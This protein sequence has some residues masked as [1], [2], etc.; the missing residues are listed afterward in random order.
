MTYQSAETL[1]QCEERLG[2][3]LKRYTTTL[4]ELKER[5]HFVEGENSIMTYGE[6][7]GRAS[8]TR[9]VCLSDMVD[10]RR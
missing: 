6:R 7:T 5:F 1:A 2:Q 4:E 10:P 8:H 9:F 3:A